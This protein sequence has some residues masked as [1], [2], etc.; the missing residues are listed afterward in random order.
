MLLPSVPG[1]VSKNGPPSHIG[2]VMAF[3][4]LMPTL[5]IVAHDTRHA[6][7]PK[8]N[9]ALGVGVI[10]GPLASGMTKLLVQQEPGRRHVAATLVP[11]EDSRYITERTQLL[12]S[13][14][15][16]NSFSV[17]RYPP[18]V[19]ASQS[20]ARIRPAELPRPVVASCVVVEQR[21]HFRFSGV[22]RFDQG[23]KSSVP[24]KTSSPSATA[25]A[26][27]RR[28]NATAQASEAAVL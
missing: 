28:S 3:H 1:H 26:P 5:G 25:S 11:P 18:P 2:A 22:T 12:P 20:P 4:V 7:I 17:A 15:V 19:N 23:A 8:C 16:S 24:R 21:Q 13:P 9:A 6:Y 27:L 10:H 14:P